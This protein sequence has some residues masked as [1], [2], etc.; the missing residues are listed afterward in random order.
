[1]IQGGEL[2]LALDD[3]HRELEVSERAKVD[4]MPLPLRVLKKLAH[5]KLLCCFMKKGY[6]DFYGTLVLSGRSVLFDAK[7]T[8]DERG[9]RVAEVKKHQLAC[10]RAHEHLGALAFVLVRCGCPG[11]R[12]GQ[13]FALPPGEV[14]NRKG[15]IPWNILDR[16]RLADGVRWLEG[17]DGDAG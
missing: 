11:E 3:Y 4:K 14:E 1:M 17:Y 16:W 7:D 6:V 12:Y 5:G 8:A 15:R 2:E 9:F 10:L 13:G